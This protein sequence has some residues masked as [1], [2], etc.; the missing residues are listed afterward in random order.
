MTVDSHGWLIWESTTFL[1]PFRQ[2]GAT[3]W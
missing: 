3:L 1:G 2:G